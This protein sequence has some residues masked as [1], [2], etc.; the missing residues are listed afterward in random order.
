MADSE[1]YIASLGAESDIWSAFANQV[2]L[3]LKSVLILFRKPVEENQGT[4]KWANIKGNAAFL[5]PGE[6]GMLG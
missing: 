3:F 2:D 1:V 5:V 6:K 4:V